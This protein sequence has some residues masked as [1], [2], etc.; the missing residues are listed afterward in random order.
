LLLAAHNNNIAQ[1]KNPATVCFGWGLFR[2]IVPLEIIITVGYWTGVL[3]NEG[4]HPATYVEVME[5]GVV[6]G[7]VFLDGFV[8]AR[9]HGPH[10]CADPALG[11]FF[12]V[13]LAYI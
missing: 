6:G 13:G 8:L 7:L 4:G 2:T 9:P 5:H 10:T 1:N 12:V 3:V 11:I